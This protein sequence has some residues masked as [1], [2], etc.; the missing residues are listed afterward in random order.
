MLEPSITRLEDPGVSEE[1]GNFRSV[2][3]TLRRRG[4]RKRPECVVSN[5]TVCLVLLL[6][7]GWQYSSPLNAF[8]PMA[9]YCRVCRV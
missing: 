9:I 8:H 3:W 5:L 7:N 4:R 6:V 2:M 1:T